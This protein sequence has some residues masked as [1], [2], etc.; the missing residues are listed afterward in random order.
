MSKTRH[1]PGPWQHIGGDGRKERWIGD[2]D[3]VTLC[4]VESARYRYDPDELEANARLIAAAPEMLEALKW[5]VETFD[6]LAAVYPSL[7]NERGFARAKA[8]IKKAK[9]E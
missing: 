5:C 3:A 6:G 1:T 2:K 9:G 7:D 4:V 8:V